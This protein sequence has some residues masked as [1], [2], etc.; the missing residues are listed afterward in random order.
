[1]LKRSWIAAFF[2]CC[3]TAVSAQTLEF[4]S[5]DALPPLDSLDDESLA[6]QARQLINRAADILQVFEQDAQQTASARVALEEQLA[7][8]KADSTSS[9][10]FLKELENAL[11]SAK[12]SEKAALKQA[13]KAQKVVEGVE[14]TAEMAP[15]EQRKNLPKAHKNLSALLPKPPP[16]PPA[17]QPIAEVIG[18]VAVT[19]PAGQAPAPTEQAPEP[20]VQDTL[21][22]TPATSEEPPAAK[23]KKDK[24]TAP[25][26]PKFKAYDPAAD[27]LLN[28]PARPCAFVSDI[29]DEFS[30]E[31]R[32]ETPTEEL[33]RYTNPVLK[34]YLQDRDHVLCQASLSTGNGAYLLN[35]LFTLND[36]NA[37]RSFGSL[38][39]NGVLI[40]KFLDG[41]TFT[42][43]N[44]RS[45]E[46]QPSPDNQVFTFR[47][48]FAVEP[49]MF[50]KM[51]KSLLDKARVA[52]STGYEDYDVQ[53]V[54][55]LQRQLTCLLKN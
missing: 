31:R 55:F 47:G 17:E 44:L 45:D 9:P 26:G 39:R 8:A 38:P 49:G 50:K 29:R 19:D 36:A 25:S 3:Q 23:S 43:Y 28:P 54:D 35:L 20:V 41:E 6:E 24:K 52:W 7:G 1:M 32:R 13:Q 34:P 10:D 16:P 5:L 42:L 33:F 21:T 46:G 4:P 40:L 14:K 11:K 30:G 18:T 51:Q 37:R 2:F 12:K 15:A 27:V 48:Q 53:N 22:S